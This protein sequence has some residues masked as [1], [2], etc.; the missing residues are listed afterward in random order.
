M[1]HGITLILKFGHNVTLFDISLSIRVA[2][3]KI[4]KLISSS[5]NCDSY[6]KILFLKFK[7]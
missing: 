7:R 4:D 3:N 6:R 5:D 2:K 1:G